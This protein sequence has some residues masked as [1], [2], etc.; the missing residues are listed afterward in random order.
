MAGLSHPRWLGRHQKAGW[1]D[2]NDEGGK[3]D[4]KWKEKTERERR[5]KKREII[6][7]A[8]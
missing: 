8:N 6:G 7:R 5:K 1:H 4:A 3:K 2:V